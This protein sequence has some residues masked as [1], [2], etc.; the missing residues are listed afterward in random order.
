MLAEVLQEQSAV[1]KFV[2]WLSVSFIAFSYLGYPA[3]LAFWSWLRP[4]AVRKSFCFPFVSII[5]PVHNG[6]EYVERKLANLLGQMDY[7]ADKYEVI[8]VS[9]GSTDGT[10]EAAQ[11]ITDPRFR[12]FILSVRSGKA[13]A[14][15]L[16]VRQARGEIV[17]FN[18]IRQTMAPGAVRELVAN[19]SDPDV[20][21]V[22]GEMVLVDDQGRVRPQLGIYYRYEQWIR[23]KESAIH[24]MI[25]SAGA[26]SAIRRN[27]FRPLPGQVILDDIY[28][29][30][31]IVLQGYRTVFDA[32]ALAYDPHDHRSEFQRKQ[33]TLT[34]N[35][36]I[37]FLLPTILTLRNPLL[38]LYLF[39]KV[40]RLIVPFFLLAALGVN[41]FLPS[42]FYAATLGAQVLFY[43]TA[44]ESRRLR[45]L[46]VIGTVAASGSTFVLANCA[47]LLGLFFFLR[48][49]PEI[50]V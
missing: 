42:G 15:N 6:V 48:R 11:R 9:D 31:Q 20:G 22:T 36:Q 14:L 33:R 46:P 37:L 41:F 29:P 43:L 24:S 17:V 12:L 13:N 28:T 4:R 18:D 38:V 5:V 32:S 45:K 44:F 39:H 40:F 3:L 26:F 16:G 35:Y 27:L 47:A 1:A 7:P 2:F 49:K 34:G 25:G 23:R 19:F 30:M 8:L 50:W 21:A 10:L